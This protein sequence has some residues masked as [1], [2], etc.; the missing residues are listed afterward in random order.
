M[1]GAKFVK[2]NKE[3]HEDKIKSKI[4]FLQ[5]IQ[6][7]NVYVAIFNKNAIQT[8]GRTN[9]KSSVSNKRKFINDQESYCHMSP[10][11]KII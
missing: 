3:I 6:T 2:F 8:D 1:E 5:R 7:K 11:K 10:I 4:Q 9:L